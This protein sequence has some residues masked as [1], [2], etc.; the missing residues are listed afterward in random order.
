MVHD[1]PISAVLISSDLEVCRDFYESKVGLA[2]SPRTIKNHL[3]FECG[4]GTTLLVYFRPGENGA[5][6]TQARFWSNDIEADVAELEGRGVA[7]EDY[8]TEYIKTVDHIATTQG[9]GRSAWFKDP[10]GNTIALY[11]PE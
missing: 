10:D 2:L 11:Q 4:D 6:H 3:L 1:N 9:I 8:D 5:D 7:F